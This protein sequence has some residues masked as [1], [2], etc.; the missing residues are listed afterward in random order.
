MKKILLITLLSLFLLT[1]CGGDNGTG[2]TI[3][4][5][6]ETLAKCLTEKGMA[7]YGAEWCSHCKTQKE[8]FGDA[9]QYV[10]YTEC[11]DNTEK[12]TAEG[13]QGF[14][15]WKFNGEIY[16]GARDL[17]ELASITGCEY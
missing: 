6:E 7:M 17:T 9:F 4:N 5:K 12:C 8:R 16:P 3:A 13:I 14:P 2:N 15:S 11:P 1:A 10:D